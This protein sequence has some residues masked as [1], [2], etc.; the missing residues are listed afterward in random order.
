MRFR[1]VCDEDGSRVELVD[2]D[3]DV[4]EEDV[5]HRD[6]QAGPRGMTIT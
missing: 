1:G 6:I 2:E 5:S 3:G 4:V